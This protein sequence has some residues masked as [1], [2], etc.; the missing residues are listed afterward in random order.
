[1]EANVGSVDRGVRVVIGLAL[2]GPAI[3]V[4]R[5]A[6]WLGIIGVVPLMTAAFRFCPL[7]VWWGEHV[8]IGSEEIGHSGPE[9][10]GGYAVRVTDRAVPA[11]CHRGSE[12]CCE[13]FFSTN[14]TTVVASGGRS[15]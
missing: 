5:D 1:M 2:H 13:S 8:S 4:E 9:Q 11:L 6:R 10:G 14:R 15:R 7:S 3:C 12:V